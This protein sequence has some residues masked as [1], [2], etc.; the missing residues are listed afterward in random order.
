MIR[1]ITIALGVLMLALQGFFPAAEVFAVIASVLWPL[2]FV[3]A[4]CTAKSTKRSLLLYPCMLAGFAVKYLYTLGNEPDSILTTEIVI[5][6]IAI[7]VFLAFFIYG[8]AYRKLNN[9]VITLI[10]PV[11]FS[12]VLLVFSQVLHLG[13][14]INPALAVINVTLLAQSAAILGETGLTFV[15]LWLCAAIIFIIDKKNKRS[16]IILSSVCAALIIF[17]VVFGAVRLSS[18]T[19]KADSLKIASLMSLRFGLTDPVD[20]YSEEEYIETFARSMNEAAEKSPDIIVTSEEYAFFSTEH[21]DDCMEKV[22][23]IIK[24]THIPTLFC[25]SRYY[26]ENDKTMT[27]NQAMLFDCDGNLICEYNKHNRILIVETRTVP[28]GDYAPAEAMITLKGKQLKVAMAICFDLND[29]IF[30]NRMSNDVDLI[31][32]PSWDWED[33]CYTQP[34]HT[35]LRAIERNAP[36]VKLTYDGIIYAANEYGMIEDKIFTLGH[37]GEVFF[38]NV[39]ID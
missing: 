26:P 24:Q 19:D 34:R 8:I 7:L 38:L 23:R 12:A 21:F 5:F 10:F 29:E 35:C 28:E 1:L 18:K 3:Y 32:A 30:M 11:L 2:C 27:T 4:F 6:F 9:G 22:T 14:I 25:V 16:R 36:L 31:L 15:L 20:T 37:Y 13:N 33:V 17:F 39:P